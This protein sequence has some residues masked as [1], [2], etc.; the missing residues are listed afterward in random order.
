[1]ASNIRD[2]EIGRAL[3]TNRNAFDCLR[4]LLD[5]LK[6][7]FV[8][9]YLLKR[10]MELRWNRITLAINNLVSLLL[11]RRLQLIDIVLALVGLV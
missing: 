1:M 7:I 10:I 11:L 6:C 2:I 3:F 4:Q 8:I 5:L 9:G